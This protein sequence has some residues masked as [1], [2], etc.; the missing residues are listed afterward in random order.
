MILNY[1]NVP[2]FR[3]ESMTTREF[4]LVMPLLAMSLGFCISRKG[5][6]VGLPEGENNKAVSMPSSRKA[7]VGTGWPL[8]SSFE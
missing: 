4:H 2:G 5:R 7:L 8:P 6:W 1:F 3:L